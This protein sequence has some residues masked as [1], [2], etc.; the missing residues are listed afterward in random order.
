MKKIAFGLISFLATGFMLTN[1]TTHIDGPYVF[2]KGEQVVIKYIVDDNGT[3]TIEADSV[4]IADKKNVTLR[5]NT[6]EPGKTFPVQLKDQLKNEE[7]VYPKADKLLVISD[8]E[9]N[10]AAFKNL[11][12]K[13]G[14]ID[15]SF[16]WKFGNGQLVLTGDFVDR[17]E[18]VNEVLWLI[19]SL[20][21]KAK[22]AGGYIHFVLGNHEIMN[23]SGDLR[24]VHPKYITS[25]TLLNAHFMTLYDE[26][27]E[28]GRWLRTKNIM[29]KIGGILFTHGGISAEVNML[30]ISL[31][32]INQL[33][34]P[35]YADTTYRYPDLKLD[36]LFND[37]G[38]F[39]Y[40]GYYIGQKKATQEQI[41]ETLSKFKAT[42]IITGHSLV[43]DTISVWYKE[44]VINTDVHH[45]SGK[46]EALFIE[47]KNYYRVTAKGEKF[48]L[49]SSRRD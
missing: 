37:A 32:Q 2:Y 24:Y 16:D 23:L 19:Y 49:F 30:D 6:D 8:I 15:E 5:V 47:G 17:G 31:P 36:T 27:S 46:S 22:A 14:V 21:E 34:R 7:S 39:W 12:V 1:P 28:L 25:A 18:Q 35:Y 26:Q 13:S 33:S 10:F 3:K 11:L 42:R 43:G 41:K 29:E 20:E 9:G 38:P 44:R 48:L 4:A 40:R 45:A